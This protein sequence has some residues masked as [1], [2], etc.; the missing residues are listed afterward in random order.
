MPLVCEECGHT[1]TC[2]TVSASNDAILAAVNTTAAR[3]RAALAE[4]EM[5]QF[6]TYFACYI[7]ALEEQK[8]AV[9]LR[10]QAVVYPILLLPTEITARIF[11]DCLPEDGYKTMMVRRGLLPGLALWLSRAQNRPLSLTVYQNQRFSKGR[12]VYDDI[13]GTEQLDVSPI[14]SR[15]GCLDISLLA[16]ETQPLASW[17]TAF[18]R[19]Q[20]L[21]LWSRD[22]VLSDIL[23]NT[24]LRR[25][26]S[27]CRESRGN[28]DFQWFASTTLTKLEI[29]PGGYGVL[30]TQFIKILHNFPALEDLACVVDM[31]T[32]H[33]Q[34]PL[35]F[36]NKTW[37]PRLVSSISSHFPR[38]NCLHC[39][40]SLHSEVVSSFLTRSACIIRDLSC[41]FREDGPS[42]S[43]I[44]LV[45]QL[46]PS[47]E[48]LSIGLQT[49]ICYLLE[50]INTKHNEYRRAPLPP[51]TNAAFNN[52]LR[53]VG[54]ESL[55]D[56]SD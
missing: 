54:G 42:D 12:E 45:L 35:T 2:T 47:V 46:F 27:W 50:G 52:Q 44:W 24:P 36:P 18:P 39:T 40:S 13:S 37:S 10:L 43:D 5:A 20:Y 7:S 22:S 48:T 34:P 15:L 38:L 1:S 32:F 29:R 51:P 31:Q 16:N 21:R 17:N 33:H 25:E 3:D 8:E 14:L 30:A 6:K 26:L 9:E 23:R 11:V 53:R 56:Y 41:E 19:L 4:I 28:L 55:C 49:D